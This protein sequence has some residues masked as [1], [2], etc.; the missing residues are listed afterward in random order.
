MTP[1]FFKYFST[2]T[3]T[4]KTPSSKKHCSFDWFPSTLRILKLKSSWRAST[5]R[6]RKLTKL[7]KLWEEFSHLKNWEI[8]LICS[9]LRK[10]CMFRSRRKKKSSNK[11]Q[12]RIQ[13]H[14]K[15]ESER[16]K[17]FDFPR[18]LRKLFPTSRQILRDGFQSGREKVSGRREEKELARLKVWQQL[19][20]KKRALL[21][22]DRV[23][24]TE[25][26]QR[27]LER[28]KETDPD[29][30]YYRYWTVKMNVYEIEKQHG[31][32]RFKI[33][34]EETKIQVSGK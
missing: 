20:G 17:E 22:L 9:S 30:C 26:S 19:V 3:R 31:K 11:S 15:R 29:D 27:K 2:F 7:R 1:T 10:I 14:Q 21:Q 23:L 24:A 6:S 34:I 28:R 5:F 33:N 8:L 4:K 18:T 25:R 32:K 16:R 12:S 13:T